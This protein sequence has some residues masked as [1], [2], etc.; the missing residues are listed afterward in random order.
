M[1][2]GL[3]YQIRFLNIDN[4]DIWVKISQKGYSG[5]VTTLN[6]AGV[7][8]VVVD[9]KS[10][11]FYANDPIRASTAT[12]KYY[13]DGTVPLSTFASNDDKMWLVEIWVFNG[14]YVYWTGFISQDDCLEDMTP[15][16]NEITLNCNDGLGLLKQSYFTDELGNVLYSRVSFI[17]CLYYILR[18]TGLN[19]SVSTHVN[20]FEAGM[21]DRTVN[22]KNTPLEQLWVDTRSFLLT[23][24]S[25]Q[26]YASGPNASIIKLKDKVQDSYTVLQRMLDAW[27]LTIVQSN[28]QWWILRWFE[29]KY[30][31]NIIPGT[32]YPD[33]TFTSSSYAQTKAATPIGSSIVP[34]NLTQTK[35]IVRGNQ[36]VR[37]TFNYEQPQEWILNS[38]LQHLGALLGSTTTGTGV[39]LVTTKDYDFLDWRTNPNVGVTTSKFIRVVTNW[40]GIETDRYGAARTGTY[41]APGSPIANAGLLSAKFDVAINDKANLSF[42]FR[43]NTSNSGP[44]NWVW[45]I[46]L[47][48]YDNSQQ[49]G[50]TNVSSATNYWTARTGLPDGAIAG[51]VSFS[52][53]QDAINWTDISIDMP[54]FPAD[55]LVE[56]YAWNFNGSGTDTY[57]KN[58]NLTIYSYINN[59]L[60]VNGHYNQ[61]LQTA[62]IL[63][64]IE[65][66]VYLDDSPKSW[67]KGCMFLM[68]RQ[69]K[70][71]AW[72][73]GT[74]S[75]S[76][77]FGFIQTV[78]WM[79]FTNKFRAKID[80]SYRGIRKSGLNEYI[81]A[82]SV[83][84]FDAIPNTFF[85]FGQCSF[86]LKNGEWSGTLQEIYNSTEYP[87]G[88]TYPGTEFTNVFQY[89]FNTR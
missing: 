83:M 88:Y 19:I 10:G 55:G 9:Y 60:A 35:Q 39:N 15:P 6:G 48:T 87:N 30:F 65:K 29:L 4:E 36:Y 76:Q 73:R 74:I 7:S 69:T 33:S 53:T 85:I 28:G 13:N 75:E 17:N 86:D 32:F 64:N 52:I 23:S 84:S 37:N 21:S 80:G 77:R 79:Y 41:S 16:P 54:A 59:S 26:D 3:K 34:I 44:G 81:G 25:T 49:W 46:V 1:A 61:S 56:F 71:A 20:T 18:Q 66:I 47:R 12:I 40:L 14:Q 68:D 11:D 2:Y 22:S 50:L 43:T 82:A 42:S 67:A 27:G 57:Y 89:L 70:T 38:N 63:K 31:N 72:H 51:G 8:P 5:A 58:I 24:Q 45:Y 78:D 62:N